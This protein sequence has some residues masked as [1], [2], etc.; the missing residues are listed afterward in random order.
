MANTGG[1]NWGN[2]QAYKNLGESGSYESYV[3][4]MQQVNPPKTGEL[5][6]RG[7]GKWAPLGVAAANF[8]TQA[9]FYKKLRDQKLQAR[10]RPYEET[11]LS[12]RPVQGIPKEVSSNFLSEMD[13]IRPEYF[14]SDAMKTMAA[15]AVAGAQKYKA[16]GDYTSKEADAARSDQQRY[17]SEMREN[18]KIQL[19]AR[20]ENID[21]RQ[22]EDEYH[23]AAS[24]D[25]TK[26]MQKLFGTTADQAQEAIFNENRYNASATM[27][28]T[29]NDIM[30]KNWE[31]GR[32]TQLMSTLDPTDPR[33][34]DLESE[35]E[36]LNNE[37]R[38]LIETGV[39]TTGEIRSGLFSGKIPRSR[40]VGKPTYTST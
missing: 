7:I 36:L 14:G 39:P 23:A 27:T 2:P 25:H 9:A 34:Y 32:K 31:I 5:I 12:V 3:Q 37:L 11:G 29:Q 13:R 22:Q 6:G 21:R 38:Y 4:G 17:D 18:E 26:D 10:I 19:A 35:I 8:G 20:K 16:L 40:L 28:R 33:Y 24:L 15:N 1:L 30:Y